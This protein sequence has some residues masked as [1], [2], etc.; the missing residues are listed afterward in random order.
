MISDLSLVSLRDKSG[1]TQKVYGVLV[2]NLPNRI[3]PYS[4]LSKL[5]EPLAA[6]LE[7]ELELE[8]S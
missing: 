6:L 4:L 2:S 5:L 1:F 3:A 8:P 7:P